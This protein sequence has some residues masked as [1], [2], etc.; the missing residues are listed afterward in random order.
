M[1]YIAS[2]FPLIVTLTLQLA[3]KLFVTV[4]FLVT[5]MVTMAACDG[6]Y[7]NPLNQ[8]GYSK[9][10]GENTILASANGSR[11]YRSVKQVGN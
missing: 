6:S 1:I 7:D 2:S 10:T 4:M 8:L 5:F 9:S 3:M 11:G